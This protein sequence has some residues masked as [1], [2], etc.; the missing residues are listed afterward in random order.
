[1]SPPL[2]TPGEHFYRLCDYLF[3]EKRHVELSGLL[4]DLLHWLEVI[5]SSTDEEVGFLRAVL[6]NAHY[7][8]D[9]YLANP[10]PMSPP[11]TNPGKHFNRLCDFL[12]DETRYK[13]LAGL[14]NDLLH[15]LETIFS[16]NDA[17]VGVVRV[18]LGDVYSSEGI[19]Q[20]AIKQFE[21]ALAVFGKIDDGE[22]IAGVR[23]SIK[24]EERKMMRNLIWIDEDDEVERET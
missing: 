24:R 4:T 15:S 18:K 3:K 8:G 14:L 9:G 5:F 17:G 22:W 20:K 19:P 7:S 12:W 1:M 11:L 2:T 10:S 6:D 13:E 21:G 16:P 23:M